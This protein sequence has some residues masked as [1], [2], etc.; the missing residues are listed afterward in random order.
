MKEVYIVLDGTLPYFELEGCFETFEGA[1][2]FA[3]E[4]EAELDD[5]QKDIEQYKAEFKH[6]KDR[7]D[8]WESYSCTIFKGELK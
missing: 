2:Q 4:Y 8:K 6:P 7:V 1:L 3:A 5:W